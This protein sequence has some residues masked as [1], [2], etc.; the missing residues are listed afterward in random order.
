M[1]S[2]LY[3]VKILL[4]S[5]RPTKIWLTSKRVLL[6]LNF[7]IKF[8]WLFLKVNGSGYVSSLIIYDSKIN[9]GPCNSKVYLRYNNSLP[10][11]NQSWTSN[12]QL[13]KYTS[14]VYIKNVLLKAMKHAYKKWRNTTYIENLMLN[15]NSMHIPSFFQKFKIGI[16]ISYITF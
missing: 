10:Q 11:V 2:L 9:F 13:Y 5:D 7:K 4:N 15:T 16:L 8:G 14:I 3:D 12:Y 6:K 1:T